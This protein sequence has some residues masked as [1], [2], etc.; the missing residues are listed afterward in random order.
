MHRTPALEPERL[1]ELDEVVT[2]QPLTE[3]AAVLVKLA[4]PL[5]LRQSESLQHRSLARSLGRLLPR[6]SWIKQRRQ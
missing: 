5:R 6:R 4:P 2:R 1:P 3:A